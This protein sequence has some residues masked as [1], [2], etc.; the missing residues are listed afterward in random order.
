MRRLILAAALLAVAASSVAGAG[1]ALSRPGDYG[2]AP[3]RVA[4]AVMTTQAVH[5]R[6]KGYAVLR[7]I[8]PNT[9]RVTLLMSRI[10]PGSHPA[11]IRVLA[12]TEVCAGFDDRVLVNLGDVVAGADRVVGPSTIT[13]TGKLGRL[14]D[15]EGYGSVIVVLASDGSTLACGIIVKD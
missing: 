6:T 13:R 3:V 11:E 10:K 8:A 12:P 14:I 5:A 7:Q 15:A 2:T 1:F 9:I 4:H